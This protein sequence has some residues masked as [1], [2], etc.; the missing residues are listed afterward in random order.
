[1]SVLAHARFFEV[2]CFPNPLRDALA[3]PALDLSDGLLDV[4]DGPGIGCDVDPA[5]V[6]RYEAA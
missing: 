2:N 1:M 6:V 5:A 4:P 3:M